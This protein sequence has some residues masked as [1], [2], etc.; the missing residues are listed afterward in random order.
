MNTTI[1]F[2]L[3]FFKGKCKWL[4][5]KVWRRR[6]VGGVG[7]GR[8]IRRIIRGGGGRGARRRRGV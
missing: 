7:R 2:I 8:A 5:L 3:L 4:L 1:Y 6:R